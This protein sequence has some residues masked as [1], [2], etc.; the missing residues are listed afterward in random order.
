ME[1]SVRRL[2]LW[3]CVSVLLVLCT[4]SCQAVDLVAQERQTLASLPMDA[5]AAKAQ[6]A[7]TGNLVIADDELLK[8]KTCGVAEKSRLELRSKGAFTGAYAVEA[9]VR[10]PSGGR[11]ANATLHCGVTSEGKAVSSACELFAACAGRSGF[12]AHAT[13]SSQVATS[14]QKSPP[15]RQNVTT[16]TATERFLAENISPVWREPFRIEVENAMAELQPAEEVWRLLRIEVRPHSLRFYQNGFLVDEHADTAPVEGGVMLNLTGEARVASLQ[17]CAIPAEEHLWYTVPLEGICNAAGPVDPSSFPAGGQLARAGDVPFVFALSVNGR[18]HVDIGK[19]VFEYRMEEGYEPAGCPTH[20]WPSPTQLDPRRIML[21]VPNRAYKRVWIVAASDEEP[22]ST[23]V[24]TVRFFRTGKGWELDSIARVPAFSARSAPEGSKRVPVKMKDGKAGSLWLMPVDVDP[25]ALSSD[26][27]NEPLLEVE[28][29]KEIQDFRAFPDPN[30]YGSFQ[31]GLPSAVRLYGLTFE[32]APVSVIAS[33]DRTGN[34]YV[35]PEQPVWTVQVKSQSGARHT[36][37]VTVDVQ[38][39]C[40]GKSSYSEALNV[41]AGDKARLEL[42]PRVQKFGLHKVRTTVACEGLTQSRE[43]TFLVLPPDDRKENGKTSRWGIWCWNGGHS[44]IPDPNDNLRLLWMVGARTGG[45]QTYEQR[46]VWGIG[47]DA[48]LAEWGVPDPAKQ[49]S[50]SEEFGK[51]VADIKAKNLDQEYVS[52]FAEHSVSL[53]VTHGPPSYA[54]G[55]PWWQYTDQEKASVQSHIVGAKAAFEGA[56]K[57][58]PD[59]KLLFGHCGPQFGIPFM[60]EKFPKE[61]FDGFGL[62]SPQFERMPERQPR[63]V[64]PCALYFLDKEMKEQGYTDKQRVHV[65]SYFP[66]SHRLALGHRGQADSTVRTAVLSLALGTD[67][68]ISCW[69]LDDCEDYWGTQHYGCIGL[70]G[71]VPE[72]NPKPTAAAFATMTQMLDSC[73]YDGYLPT[74]SLTAFCVRFKGSD[75]RLVY[76]LWTIRGSRPVTLAAKAGTNLVTVDENGNETALQPAAQVTLT[77]TPVWVVAR[78][79]QIEKAECGAPAYTEAP[80]Q[81][82]VMLDSFEAADWAYSADAYTRFA[83]NSWDVKRVPGPM[84]SERAASA[85]RNSKAWRITLTQAPPEKPFVGWYGVFTPP[86]PIVIPG[87]ARALGL[88]ANGNSGWGRIVYEVVDAKGE[89]YL[90]CGTKDDWNCDDVHSWSYFNFDG[91]RYV[92]F[93]LPSNSP[94]DDYREK[95]NVW[96]GHSAEGVVDLPLK[97]SKIIFEMPSHIIYV[98]QMLPVPKLTVEVDDLMA[99]YD[100]AVMMTDAPVTIQR[101]AAG[102]LRP[103]AQ[104]A[105]LPNPIAEAKEKG[106]AAPTE[107]L[108]LAPP[109]QRY[110]GTQINVSIK[111]V[112]GAKEYQVWVSAYADGRG[113]KALA[114]G[115]GAALMVGGL[116]PDFPLYFFVTYTAAD[117]RQ[118]KP[119]EGRQ[120]TLKDEFPMK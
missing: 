39:A 33:G 71:R 1:S 36:A 69:T 53:R 107:I 112:E 9:L 86:K 7:V 78:G 59:I 24:M 103:K 88:Y 23:P 119:S 34:T 99:V 104:G 61:L 115:A 94:G 29:T 16:V 19:S 50:Y 42:K 93:P 12:T 11:Q 13:V 76:C 58:A 63:G 64:E 82:R 118:S 108:K 4:A 5:E 35:H 87:K 74:G 40:G 120:T 116:Q 109:E 56:R 114:K 38:D 55:E 89:V 44:T 48:T 49:P 77:P 22:N 62:D 75:N 47:P 6:W 66:S 117:G 15:P 26:F 45:R 98:N 105:I 32:E 101:A 21:R 100:D 25:F 41:P 51:K 46:R 60:R 97:L 67:R 43:G 110:E 106:A 68:F 8:R 3:G 14:L 81:H 92:E 57:A 72:S 79:G 96:W 37:T 84:K 18:D 2:L 83:E 20:T 30:N 73:K 85:E 17:V 113:A 111:P 90:S 27:R 31:G 52:I 102:A 80:G 91:W 70:F 65:E 10:F 54:W 28:L 95:D